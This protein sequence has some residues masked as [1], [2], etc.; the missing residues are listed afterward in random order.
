MPMFEALAQ[1]YMEACDCLCEAEVENLAF[2]GKLISLE[3]GMRF[4]TD[5]LEGDVYFKSHR[6]N[7]NLDRA[8]TQFRLVELIE[9]VEPEMERFVQTLHKAKS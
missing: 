3:V 2:S 5:H 7:H 9:A 1:G 6:E 4:L 8:R